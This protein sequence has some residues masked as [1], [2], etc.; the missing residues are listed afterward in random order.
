VIGFF[1]M[2]LIHYLKSVAE[3]G[4]DTDKEIKIQRRALRKKVKEHLNQ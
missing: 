1:V 3:M 2:Y 4:F